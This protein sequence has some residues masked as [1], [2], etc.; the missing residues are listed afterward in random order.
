[1]SLKKPIEFP[2]RTLDLLNT[3]ENLSELATFKRPD[4][5]PGLRLGTS[6]FTAA[7]WEGSFYPSGMRSAKYL[8]YYATK[9]DTVEVHSTYYRCP[10]ASTV[11]GWYTKTTPDFIFA[12][13]VP[14]VITH[15]KVLVNFEREFDEFIERMDLLDDK[16]GPLLLQF[17]YFNKT[18]FKSV[19][20]F[21]ERLR[22]FL[23]RIEG[24]TIRY[25]VEI[26]NKSWLDARFADLLRE[27]KVA[28]ALTDQVWMPRPREIFEKFDPITTDFTYIRWLGD[29]KGIERQTKTWDKT[30][31]DRRA[32]LQEWVKYCYQTMQRGV[33]VYAF[34][35]NHYAGHAPATVEQFLTLWNAQSA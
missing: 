3:A 18:A 32:D 34:A 14:Q 5:I 16:L 11:K 12:A 25:A 21:L 31:V 10:S 19:G 20:E 26:R 22:F 17:R 7:G 30:I 9:F 4:A 35:N 24:T 15:E 33:K 29:R 8:S 27:H 6:A 13:K 2:Q 28:L 23:K 1:V